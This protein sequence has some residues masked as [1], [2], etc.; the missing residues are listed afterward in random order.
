MTAKRFPALF[1][2]A[3]SLFEV[4]VQCHAEP[5]GFFAVQ[6]H[7][8]IGQVRSVLVIG[9]EVDASVVREEEGVRSE[10]ELAQDR[11]DGV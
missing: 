9:D 6:G 4:L 5:V 3:R 11:H 7:P 8:I 2:A 10:I 1:L